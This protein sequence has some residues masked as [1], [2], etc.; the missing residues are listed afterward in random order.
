MIELILITLIFIGIFIL[1]CKIKSETP[2]NKETPITELN[3]LSYEMN[4]KRVLEDI[5]WYKL[6]GYISCWII[7]YFSQIKDELRA[8]GY[9]LRHIRNYTYEVS[10]R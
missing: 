3:R 10:W 2:V 7:V 1:I 4:K 5:Q 6:Q 8:K 9:H